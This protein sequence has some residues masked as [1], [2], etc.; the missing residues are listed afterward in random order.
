MEENG[1]EGRQ[2]ERGM[3]RENRKGDRRRKKER[4]KEGRKIRKEKEQG[5]MRGKRE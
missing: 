5:N 2:I 1:N 3:P 4:G